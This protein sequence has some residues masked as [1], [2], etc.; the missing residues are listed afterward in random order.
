LRALEPLLQLI[1]PSVRLSPLREAQEQAQEDLPFAPVDNRMNPKGPDL[2][3]PQ[4]GEDVAEGGVI[5]QLQ[6][7]TGRVDEDEFARQPYLQFRLQREQG[8]TGTLEIIQRLLDCCVFDGI[9]LETPEHGVEREQQRPA[10]LS[11]LAV[12]GRARCRIDWL[13]H[14]AL[15]R[16]ARLTALRTT[17]SL[18][19][20]ARWRVSRASTVRIFPRAMAAQARTSEGSFNLKRPRESRIPLSGLRPAAPAIDP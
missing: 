14:G 19:S 8:P 3:G 6:P 9:E 13:R 10:S 20:A 18:S 11:E 7:E 5:V 15:S 17:R 2:E 12:G 16:R 1:E 4:H